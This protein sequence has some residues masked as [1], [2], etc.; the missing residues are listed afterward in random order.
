MEEV[1]RR[2]VD[3]VMVVDISR[4]MLAE[5]IRP[6]RLQ[7]AKETLGNLIDRLPDQRIALVAFAGSAQ[8]FCPLTLDHAAAKIFLDILDPSLVLEPGTAMGDAIRLASSLFDPNE[9]KYKVMVLITDGED[10]GTDPL[11]AA[12]EA[13]GAGA[14]L[15]AIGVGTPAGEPIPLK[16][17]SGRVTDYVRDARGQVVTSRLDLG[18][19]ESIAQTSGGSFYVATP[20]EQEL[21]RVAETITEMDR[22]ELSSRLATNMQERFQIPLLAAV[23]ALAAEAAVGKRRRAR[24]GRER[25]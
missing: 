24:S 14:I 12:R 1:R 3:L 20:G 5:D 11:A 4:S 19:L 6:S 25:A 21:D 22:K 15:H 16:D 13:A 17:A 18:L 2:G 9:R 8:V 23:L 7:Q 10:Q